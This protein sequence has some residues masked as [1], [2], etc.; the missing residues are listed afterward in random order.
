MAKGD[1][2]RNIG[3]KFQ[4]NFHHVDWHRDDD[5]SQPTPHNRTSTKSIYRYGPSPDPGI[6]RSKCHNPN[7]ENGGVD[8]G[9]MTPWG[10]GIM[11]PCPECA[12]IEDLRALRNRIEWTDPTPEMRITPAFEAVWQ[13]IKRWDINVPGAYVGYEG[14]T[15][16]HVRA[17]LDALNKAHCLTSPELI[18]CMKENP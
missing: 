12:A 18:S 2:P 17:I 16:N 11:L 5:A 10:S 4:E 1:D 9:G 13:A 8:S 7:C 3:P 14:A 15:G 6:R